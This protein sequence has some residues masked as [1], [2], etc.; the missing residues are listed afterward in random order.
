MG[1][2][3]AKAKHQLC[4]ALYGHLGKDLGLTELDIVNYLVYSDVIEFTQAFIDE[5]RVQLV[6]DLEKKHI[7]VTRVRAPSCIHDIL[8]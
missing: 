5:A 4:V 3:L 7:S 1:D 2:N 6:N 8:D